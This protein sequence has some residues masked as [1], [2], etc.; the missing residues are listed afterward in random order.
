MQDNGHEHRVDRRHALRTRGN[1]LFTGHAPIHIRT[2]DVSVTGVCV[3]SEIS[4]PA[5]IQ[6]KLEI[7]FPLGNGHFEMMTVNIKTM[8][9]IFCNKE[10]GFK[11][12]VLFLS[13]PANL[14]KAIQV[15]CK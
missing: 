6:G 9:S 13:P 15:Y 14:V 10:D 5:K 12:G 11:V 2:L 4:I 7:N 1:F 8:H 3:V